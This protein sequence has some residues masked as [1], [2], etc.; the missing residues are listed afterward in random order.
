MDSMNAGEKGGE[1]QERG[2]FPSISSSASTPSVYPTG[3]RLGGGLDESA[4]KAKDSHVSPGWSQ[5]R[6]RAVEGRCL[7]GGAREVILREGDIWLELCT[8][9]KLMMA[10][11]PLLTE[12]AVCTG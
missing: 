2:E 10:A 12:T 4:S 5:S 8:S 11:S 9:L 3:E 6:R 1:K 7:L